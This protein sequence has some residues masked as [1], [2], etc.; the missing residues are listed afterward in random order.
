MAVG[1]DTVEIRDNELL[2]N[3]VAVSEPY[4]ASGATMP[5]M[6]VTEVPED[7][8]W[9]MGDN[10][11]RSQDSRRFGAIPVKDVIGRAFV[12]VWPFD[13]WGGL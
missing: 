3:G 2:V 13:R 9:V 7:H 8:V 4:L 1:G 11:N 6:D 5:D 10:R 12:I